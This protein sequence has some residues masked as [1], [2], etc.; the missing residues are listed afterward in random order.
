MKRHAMSL[1]QFA[2]NRCFAIHRTA[3]LVA[4]AI[5]GV[6]P[7]EAP[8]HAQAGDDTETDEAIVVLDPV[9]VTSRKIEEAQKDVP[10]SVTVLGEQA[11]EERRIDG[12]ESL[13]RE[14]PNIG[15]SSLG[16]GRSTFLSI[17]GIGPISQPLGYDD[18][19]TVTYVDGVPQ[20]LFGSDL[21]ILD[22][23]RI[24]VMRGPQGTVFGRNAQAGAINIITRQPDD[25]VEFTARGEL[26]TDWHRLGEASASG[27]LIDDELAGRLAV[28]YYGLD[29]D[30][31]NI[32]PETHD[33]G[34][35]ETGA[36]R[37]SLVATPGPDTRITLGLFGQRDDNRPSNFVLKNAPGFPVVAAEPEGGIDRDLAGVSLTASHDFSDV[38]LTSVTAFDYYDY[39]GFT[40][41]SEALTYSRVFGLPVDAFLPAT[42]FADIDE[43]Q[44]GVYQELRLNSSPQADVLWVGGLVYYYDDFERDDYYQSAFFAVTNG[45]RNNDYSTNSYAAFGEATAPVPG[46]EGLKFTAGLRYTRDEK[47]YDVRYRSNGFPGTVPSFQQSG[48]LYY[49]LVTGRAALSYEL[50][51]TSNVYASVSRG[52]KSGGFPNFTNNAPSGMPDEPYKESTSW[53]YEVGTKNQLLDGRMLLNAALFFNDVKDQQLFAFDSASFTFVPQPL[54]TTSYGAEL[55][56]GYRLMPGLDLF[57]SAGYTN[58]EIENVSADIAASTNAKDGNRVPSTPEFT[59]SVTLQYRTSATRLGLPDDADIF[60]LVQYQY[61]GERAADVGNNFDLDAYQVL[62]ARVGL[63]FEHFDIYAFGQ[64][65]TDDRPEY[66][67]LFYG[68]G[69]AAV[70]VGHGRVVGIGAQLRF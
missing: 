16:D 6:Q 39:S 29:G 17:R 67:G 61:V 65:L 10:I 59:S 15:F 62:N 41:N 22:A 1:R 55:E 21:S 40:N 60:G 70:T 69:A 28:Y 27:P 53:T 37:G 34:D 20:P 24:E 13:L 35:I 8:A 51:E 52:A 66:I 19:S 12:V 56:V 25:Q 5:S 47:D 38:T 4:V 49:D 63:E 26:G 9:T 3:F 14:I 23:E 64:N 48:S 31:D 30:V 54:D 50:A 32:A 11:L 18:T 68:P 2:S 33:L 43:R 45:T 44:I 42:D 57:G 7:F 58:A 46:V 36:L